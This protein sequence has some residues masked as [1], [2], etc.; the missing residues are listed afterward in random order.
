MGRLTE[1]ASL[2]EYP[3]EHYAGRARACAASLRGAELEAFAQSAGSMDTVA[4]QERFIDTFDL[5]PAG[6]LEIGWHVFG[7]QYERGELLVV[8][9]KRLRELGIAERGELPDHLLH[10]LPLL[11]AVDDAERATLI[12]RYVAP[13][14]E[15]IARAVPDGNPFAHL[16]RALGAALAQ[17]ADAVPVGGRHG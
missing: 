1:L 10:V 14:V 16:V 5:N 15:K 8:L 7:E 6:T 11:D 9:R 3:D 13:A 12:E 4:L 2:F 17:P